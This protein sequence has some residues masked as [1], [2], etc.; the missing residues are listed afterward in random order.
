MR[1]F[2]TFVFG[3]FCGALVGAVTALLLAPYSGEELREQAASRARG[4]REDVRQ[5]YLSRKAQLEQDLEE[6]RRPKS[7]VG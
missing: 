5:A 7:R 4:L 3:A 2:M 6:L 1:R